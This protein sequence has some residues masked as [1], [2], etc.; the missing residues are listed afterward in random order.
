MAAD[1]VGY[2]RLMHADEAGTHGRVRGLVRE[3]ILPVVAEH[4]GRIVK[5]RGDGFLASFESPVEAVRCAIVLQQSMI[6][7]NLQ[8]PKAQWIQY[9]IGVNLGDVIIEEDDI[10]GEGV[11]IAA[12]LEQI[13]DPGSV[14]ISGAIYEQVKHKLVCSYQSLGDR[15]VKNITDPVTIYRVLPDRAAIERAMRW[16]A[17]ALALIALLIGGSASA[18]WYFWQ[19]VQNGAMPAR[20][21]LPVLRPDTSLVAPPD[22]STPAA[23][24][25]VSAPQAVNSPVVNPPAAP[26]PPARVPAPPPA[27][28]SSTP[29]APPPS[30][31]Q[32]ESVAIAVMPLV[33][34]P[35]K[36]TS[37]PTPAPPPS[38]QEPEMVLVPGGQFRMGS[39]EDPSEEPVHVVLIHSFWIGKYSVTVAEWRACAAARACQDTVGDADQ[40]MTNASWLDAMAYVTWLSRVTGRQ[41]RLPSEA[42]WE[43]AARGGTTSRYWWG[44]AIGLGHANCVECGSP[45]D[46]ARPLKVGS[47]APNPFGLFDMAGGVSEWVAD[48]WHPNYVGAPK[49]GAA[50]VCQDGRSDHVLRGGSW[51]SAPNLLR[52]SDREHYETD[53]RYPGNGFRVA[54]SE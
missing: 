42:E 15:K 39:R 12:R 6:G 51:M 34:A 38:I 47:F 14:Y 18:S 50:W 22:L 53:I 17:P 23:Q 32:P 26:A 33:P 48:C 16:R 19:H 3:L 35:A 44:N 9:R 11:N 49:A 21:I 8:L 31:P 27:S 25:P 10:Y 41:Y 43:Y 24:A 7:H 37:P 20:L 40:P 46:P 29:V 54:R 5:T 28:P 45:H 36:A 1:I 30:P 4:R 13:A 2:T 52:V